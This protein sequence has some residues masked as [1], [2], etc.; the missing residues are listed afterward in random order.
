MVVRIDQ[1]HHGAGVGDDH[2]WGN[3]R[4]VR[5]AEDGRALD[6]WML[7]SFFVTTV[8]GTWIYS[9]APGRLLV[10][11]RADDD[12]GILALLVLDDGQVADTL[13]VPQL[14]GAPPRAR[15]TLPYPNLLE[16]ASRQVFR[17][18][19]QQR[20]PVGSAP[21]RWRAQDSQGCGE[22]A[23]PPGG[24]GCASTP[25]RMDGA[26]AGVPATRRRVASID[27]AALPR[28]RGGQ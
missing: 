26:A 11:T 18:G 25:L 3:G 5:F 20:V 16:L 9:D 1:S 23:G 12:L 24:G 4:I 10:T 27:D 7:D 19:G 15:R 14:P 22:A 28:H 17:G 6:P 13:L 2:R 8:L 21:L